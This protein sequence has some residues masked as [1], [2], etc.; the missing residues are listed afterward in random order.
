MQVSTQDGGQPTS[1]PNVLMA[2][3]R[4][5][6]SAVSPGNST[7]AVRRPIPRTLAQ[8]CSS[9]LT[10]HPPGSQMRNWNCEKC[11]VQSLARWEMRVTPFGSNSAEDSLPESM[12]TTTVCRRRPFQVQRNL[13]IER[14]PIRRYQTAMSVIVLE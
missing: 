6:R 12:N 9:L 1:W 7:G 10:K 5:S 4:F 3:I 13:S 14:L 2:R 11:C 8:S